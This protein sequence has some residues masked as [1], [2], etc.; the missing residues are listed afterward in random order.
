M[1]MMSA[2]LI[3]P[4][5]LKKMWIVTILLPSF[6]SYGA[7][8]PSH[9]SPSST[10]SGDG[11]E[12]DGAP[13]DLHDPKQAHM[14]VESHDHPKH[15]AE[16]SALPSREE[17]EGA[18]PGALGEEVHDDPK[19][20]HVE[21]SASSEDES[22][23]DPPPHLHETE[24]DEAYYRRLYERHDAANG[25]LPDRG[26][27][28]SGHVQGEFPDVSNPHGTA[29]VGA[30]DRLNPHHYPNPDPPLVDHPSSS[31]DDDVE[32]AHEKADEELVAAARRS[33]NDPHHS[34][35]IGRGSSDESAGR[36][37]N[38]EGHSALEEED[39]R[40]RDMFEVEK[41]VL[42][43]ANPPALLG[44]DNLGMAE[45]EEQHLRGELH[46]GAP[47]PVSNDL[48]HHL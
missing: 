12:Y 39:I 28:S 26:V 8:A 6:P 14:Y 21:S 42:L 10:T 36:G 27:P 47:L 30:E 29:G 13:P 44:E 31:S 24:D 20:A 43:D 1:T 40:L 15:Q 41:D 38:H 23:T 2:W 16:S 5:K 46:P 37:D 9:S 18:P 19:Q 11:E 3:L 7:A 45:D 34:A 17:Y 4:N 22:R 48:H 33:Q 25:H 32:H 35:Y